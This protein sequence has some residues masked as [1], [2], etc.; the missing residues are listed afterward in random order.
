VLG[1]AFSPDGRFLASGG[2]DRMVV[3]WDVESGSAIGQ[4]F[5]G[6]QHWVNRVAFSP[7]GRMLA[8]ASRDT[9][10][11]LWDVSLDSWR[12]RACAIADRNLTPTEWERYL[13][14]TEYRE[15]CPAN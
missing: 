12:A 11:I 10:V 9:T 2:E 3:L 4:P 13:P 15:T 6:H 5:A 1:L 8:S 7:D 14:D